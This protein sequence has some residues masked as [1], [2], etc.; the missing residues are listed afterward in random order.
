MN[1][2]IPVSRRQLITK[3][4]KLGFEGPFCG[5]K[6]FFMSHEERDITIPNPHK[7]DISVDLLQRILKQA[8]IPRR[9]WLNH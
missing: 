9:E 3:M 5:G 4:K 8:G 7:T 1:R 2:L 6:H